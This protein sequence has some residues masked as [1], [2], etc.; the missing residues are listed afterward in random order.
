M[1]AYPSFQYWLINSVPRPIGSTFFKIIERI[2]WYLHDDT[3]MPYKL[4]LGNLY[5]DKIDNESCAIE[6]E[7]SY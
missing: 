2:Y 7:V 5:S 6:V 1:R 3:Y 4:Y